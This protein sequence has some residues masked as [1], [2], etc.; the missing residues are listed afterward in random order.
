MKTYCNLLPISLR[1][2]KIAVGNDLEDHTW[3]LDAKTIAEILSPK[4]RKTPLQADHADEVEAYESFAID[5]NIEALESIKLVS[6]LEFP[7]SKSKR[8]HYLPLC[9]FL[10]SC[11]VSCHQFLGQRKG[12][13]YDD[14]KFI[15]WD[16]EVKDNVAGAA[17]L[18]PDLI[19]G[20]G[21][22][23]RDLTKARGLYWRPPNP[24]NHQLLIPVEVKGSWPE[25]VRQAG[26]YARCLFSASPLRQYAMVLGYSHTESSFRFLFFHRGGLTSSCALDLSSQ[27]DQHNF[28][29]IFLAILS[30]ETPAHAGL[31]MWCNDGEMILPGVTS[32]EGRV[33]VEKVLHDTFCI[34][35]RAPRVVSVCPPSTSKDFIVPSAESRSFGGPQ[36]SECLKALAS[37]RSRG[38]KATGMFIAMVLMLIII[39]QQPASGSRSKGESD[40]TICTLPAAVSIDAHRSTSRC[41]RIANWP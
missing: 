14:L 19:G 2:L 28:L 41:L 3:Q 33:Q 8:D 32:N 11:V 31:P 27:E 38:S 4:I 12:K 13:Y 23:D 9:E 25:L 24:T 37:G 36:R 35:G 39:L 5:M 16:C 26:T 21:L 34:R 7:K 1:T 15:V 22:Q 40:K 30:W 29:R 6:T 17:A 18:K 20:K 10:N